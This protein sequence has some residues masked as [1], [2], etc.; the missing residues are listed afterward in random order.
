MMN[1]RGYKKERAL[2]LLPQQQEFPCHCE[3]ACRESIKIDTAGCGG[4]IPLHS[5]GSRGHGGVEK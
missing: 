2:K 3:R 1:V 5:M 4:G